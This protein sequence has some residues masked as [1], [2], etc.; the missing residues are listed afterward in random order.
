MEQTGLLI[1][2]FFI[3]E[4]F[5]CTKLLQDRNLHPSWDVTSDSIAAYI[6]SNTGAERLILLKDVDGFFTEDPRKSRKAELIPELTVEQLSKIKN[7]CID[8]E[9]PNF[10]KNS[11]IEIWLV[12]G[13]HP[14]RIEKIMKGKKTKGT[15]IL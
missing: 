10:I 3:G 4:V 15:G 9:F 13:K 6:A 7:S 11:N 14:E 5:D 1:R 8:S 12:N 2:N